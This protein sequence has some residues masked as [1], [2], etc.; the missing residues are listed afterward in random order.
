MSAETLPEG[1]LSRMTPRLYLVCGLP[2][3]GKT[4][5][6][7]ELARATGAVRL[8]PDEWLEALGI[9][10]IDYDFRFRLEP[11]LLR[12][13]EELLQA[14]VGVV[15]EFG[16]WSRTE[17]EAIRHIGARTRVATELHFMDA[18]IEEL[19]ERV[20]ERG[21]PHAAFLVD[22]VL[23]EYSG[24]FERPTADEAASYDRYY[25]PNDALA[26]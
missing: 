22:K 11:Q 2:G 20:R 7:R 23:L 1:N 15:V 8:C 19:T 9:S 14:G 3:A 21:G 13:G 17:R 24:R 10:L 6:A 4:T 26:R 25:G 5:R 16:S 18:P 12:H